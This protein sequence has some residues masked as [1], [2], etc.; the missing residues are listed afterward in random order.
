M[1]RWY[2]TILLTLAMAVFLNPATATAKVIRIE[3]V[4]REIILDGYAFGDIGPYEKIV[5]RVYFV[6]DPDNP[7]NARIVDLEL[8]PRNADG[9]VEAWADFTVLRPVR[10]V[11]GGGVGLLEVSNRGGKASLSYFNGAARSLDPTEP[12]HFGDGLLMRLGLT[13]IWVGWQWDVPE[14]DGL[15]RLR[16]PVAVGAD[17]QP[18]EGLVRADW[19]LDQPAKSLH[20]GH[21]SH[22]A[23]PVIDPAH[24]DNVLTVRDG[25]MAPRAVVPRDR[26]RFAREQ[27]GNVAESR[28]DIYMESGFEAGKIYELVYRAQ[29]PRVVGLGLAAVRDMMSYAKYDPESPFHVDHG[30]AI[31]ISQTGRF[32]RHFVY[33]GFNTDE[34]G[35]KS[36][37]GVMAH[38][39][40]A[41][42]GSFN[43]RFG[44]PSRDAHRYSAFFYPTDI[45]PFS[46]RTQTDP[47]TDASDGL[48]AHAFE[49]DDL[50]NIF[51]TNTGYEYW[52]RAAG[53]IHTSV[54]GKRDIELYP[55]ERFYHLASGQHFVGRFPPPD[56]TRMADSNAYRGN[57]LNFLVTMR[58]LLTRMVEWVRDGTE[59]P[60][61]AYPRIDAGTLA[62]IDEVGFPDIPGVTFPSVAHEAYRVDFGPRWAQGI[63]D[64][65]PPELGTPFPVPLP[66][67]DEIGNEVAGLRAVEILV[68]LAT[69]APWNLRLGFP[70][71]T[72]EL[73]DFRGTY[74]ALP[75]TEAGRQATG[76]P[77][78]SIESLYAS[79]QTF[80][81]SVEDAARDLVLQGVLLE[82]DVEVV[83]RRASAHWDWI[84]ENG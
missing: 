11:P 82:E 6:F 78:P 79:K 83:V 39:A 59:P 16:V 33:Q 21:R 22:I 36:L 18:L 68:P 84:M 15:L 61:S 53:L 35:R 76:D 77:R 55:N 64:I 58:A 40:G 50:P 3:I 4:S 28:T 23:Y 74:I 54:D 31:G 52:G 70:G 5:G 41:G 60:A 57:P 37:D 29:D 66:R 13:V 2:P 56:A 49:P 38:T 81:S 71:G 42:R 72:D 62:P 80:L 34:E 43:H 51:Y 9:L 47:L 65:Q 63:I 14:R 45:F 10:P 32:L 1:T 19:T 73:T 25:R 48:F 69:Y 26:W 12:E 20:I 44:Q 67:V 27:D 30:I 7:M 8:A 24:P 17:G 75:K 46:S